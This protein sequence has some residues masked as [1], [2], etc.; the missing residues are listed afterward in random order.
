[1]IVD[2]LTESQKEAIESVEENLQIIAGA[3]S[4]KTKVIQKRIV[5]L[6]KEKELKPENIVA[7]TFTKK[8][9]MELKD[10][11]FGEYEMQLRDSKGIG[12]LTI[13]TIHEYCLEILSEFALEYLQY[14]VLNEIQ[15]ILFVQKTSSK[16]GFTDVKLPNG[17]KLDR[18]FDAKLFIEII[19]TLREANIQLPTDIREIIKKYESCLDDKEYRYLDFTTIMTKAIHLI[20]T[21]DEVRKKL[22]KIKYLLVDE[23]Q[24][25]NPVQEELIKLL[26]DN[27]TFLTVVADDD[28]S[29]YG[30]RSS[31][32]ENMITFSKRYPNV[33]IVNLVE[34]FRSS[35]GIVDC[36]NT[37]IR[38]N[39]N[40]LS[41]NCISKSNQIYERGDILGYN[42]STENSE[43]EFIV[44]KIKQLQGL[45]FT[46]KSGYNRSVGLNDIVILVYSVKH[47]PQLLFKLLNDN[48]LRYAVE[49]TRT[50]FDTQEIRAS[51]GIFKYL[52]KQISYGE[53]ELE[54][55]WISLE[56]DKGLVKKAI[57]NLSKKYPDN[58]SNN[59]EK[60]NIQHIYE[61][62]L[63]D[64]DA[65]SSRGNILFN[66]GE[67]S[68][69]I[70]D[71]E[72]INL[73]M[74]PVIKLKKFMSFIVYEAPK[75]YEQRWMSPSF[76]NIKG[77]KI[78]TYF[79][80]KGLEFPVVFMPFLTESFMFPPKVPGGISRWSIIGDIIDKDGYENN[81]ESLRRLFYV[82]VTRSEKFLFMTNSPHKI[83]LSGNKYNRK[84]STAF[85]DALCCDY[86]KQDIEYD[87]SDREKS[88]SV[89]LN[90]LN[91]ILL[92]FSYMKEFF[93]CEERFRMYA[94]YGF[95]PPLDYRMGYGKTIH[96]VLN[97]MHKA[98]LNGTILT[99]EYVEGLVEKHAHFP[100]A[101][102]STLA[103]KSS[104]RKTLKA[105]CLTQVKNYWDN[106][107]DSFEDII[108]VEQ[109]IEFRLEDKIIFNTRIDL[110]RN[111]KTGELTIVDFKS[112]LNNNIVMEQ[113]MVYALAYYKSYGVIVDEIEAYDIKSRRPIKKKV[114]QKDIDKVVMTI[115]SF[116]TKVRKGNYTKAIET[117]GVSKCKDIKCMFIDSCTNNGKCTNL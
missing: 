92:N 53:K 76:D 49:G 30:W 38:H 101:P 58:F 100:Y 39:K 102:D 98:Y 77:I 5:Y 103:D 68:T 12:D 109:P 54:F 117:D 1:M 87:F 4:G 24:D 70:D 79:Q 114:T 64:I 88:N 116:L 9:A 89:K 33:K 10:R 96:N 69:A 85:I 72:K 67:F 111:Q 60:F 62:F 106:Y 13:K 42:F 56:Y 7:F 6:V 51:M 46:D 59:W 29:I 90:D 55:D 20:K 50:L 34:N 26:H 86:V 99:V 48:E 61:S 82:G 21:N 22:K 104:L 107:K 23:Y 66:L 91:I 112:A 65:F 18:R 2:R 44:N 63:N 17:K 31:K 84:I 81:E 35:Q 80:A 47:I 25:I 83:G 94:I 37:V 41:K 95:K 110:V 32:S 36:A 43:V 8:A 28:Q 16:N 108:L 75:H 15:N 57:R 3:G 14:T 105:G 113:L 97:E 115:N 78:M 27:G 19:T 74:E 52:T 71:F 93:Q 11:V 73:K 45:K 40:R